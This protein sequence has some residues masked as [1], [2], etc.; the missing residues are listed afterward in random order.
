M[1]SHS[2]ISAGNQHSCS[3]TL[4]AALIGRIRYLPRTHVAAGC[5]FFGGAPGAGS[6]P[7][8]E[9]AGTW[10]PAC[11]R[12][13]KQARDRP[14]PSPGY[15]GDGNL[16]ATRRAAPP[17]GH[18]GAR[19]PHTGVCYCPER[20]AIRGSRTSAGGRRKIMSVRFPARHRVSPPEASG[21]E[22]TVPLRIPEND[23]TKG[24]L[25]C[26]DAA[27]RSPG[28]SALR[29]SPG[30][31]RSPGRLP[32]HQGSPPSLHDRTSRAG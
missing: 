1:P 29:S 8:A 20:S 24:R 25:G 4:A 16:P 10:R 9:S 32:G 17:R 22:R 27:D 31:R 30:S 6:G 28:R 13:P 18:C 15:P 11:Q 26:Q 5:M 3:D 21:Q 19:R 7:S 12:D 2:V 23:Y 14:L